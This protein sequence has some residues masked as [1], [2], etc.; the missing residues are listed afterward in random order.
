MVVFFHS[1]TILATPWLLQEWW[2]TLPKCQNHKRS[3]FWSC[4]SI[5]LRYVIA[6]STVLRD[7]CLTEGGEE[8]PYRTRSHRDGE[9]RVIQ[10]QKPCDGVEILLLLVACLELSGSKCEI[11]I[12]LYHAL[13]TPR[14][15]LINALIWG[16]MV[17]IHPDTAKSKLRYIILSCTSRIRPTTYVG[18][19]L[20]YCLWAGLLH[21]DPL[22]IGP[23]GW[24]IGPTIICGLPGLA[25]IEIMLW[26]T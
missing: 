13:R 19:D 15:R 25:E 12:K 1:T 23:F 22:A 4:S 6:Y 8:E 7:E 20:I 11:T 24:A 16:Y 2:S 5:Y 21:L 18:T 14:I 10:L 17:E 3:L 9:T 26:Y